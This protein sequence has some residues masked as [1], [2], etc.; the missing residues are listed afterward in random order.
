MVTAQMTRMSGWHELEPWGC[1]AAKR[2]ATLKVNT[3]LPPETDV[4][5]YLHLRIPDWAEIAECTIK[6]SGTSTFVDRLGPVPRWYTAAGKVSDGGVIN[7]I[8]ISGKG[9][10]Q[11]VSDREIVYRHT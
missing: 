2:R 3:R 5:V 7:I 8:L 10:L 4:I 6:I 1:W 9:F 11:S